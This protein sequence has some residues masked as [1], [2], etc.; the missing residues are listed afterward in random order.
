M[1]TL[2]FRN[3]RCRGNLCFRLC[4]ACFTRRLLQPRSL[5]QPSSNAR[6]RPDPPPSAR[7]AGTCHGATAR[8][9]MAM[10]AHLPTIYNAR[11]FVE[12]GGVMSYGPNALDSVPAL[13]R[14]REGVAQRVDSRSV[15][16]MRTA[17]LRSFPRKRESRPRTWVPATGSPRRERRGVPLAGT[18]REGW[19]LPLPGN[20]NTHSSVVVYSA[21]RTLASKPDGLRASLPRD[22]DAGIDRVHP[23]RD[24]ATARRDR[25]G[26]DYGRSNAE[27]PVA[28]R[29]IQSHCKAGKG[30][31]NSQGLGVGL[32]RAAHRRQTR[33]LSIPAGGADG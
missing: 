14:G 31:L 33:F 19:F 7:R 10:A 5:R 21:A 15:R 13:R 1:G 26:T 18:R 22:Q 28:Y 30:S 23:P 27:A 24:F 3:E 2:L 9:S 6:K 16:E 29:T 4:S 32:A 17:K 12:T 8:A 25:I 20:Q 11:E